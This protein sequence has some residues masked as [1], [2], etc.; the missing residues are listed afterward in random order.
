MSAENSRLRKFS[1]CLLGEEPL[2]GA[3]GG[4]GRGD[5]SRGAPAPPGGLAT[6][7]MQNTKLTFIF[8]S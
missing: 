7:T 8:L 5:S 4:G 1:L 6:V 3:G 2:R